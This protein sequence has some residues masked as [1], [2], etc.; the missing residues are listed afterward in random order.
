MNT[1][2]YDIMC[3]PQREKNKKYPPNNNLPTEMDNYRCHSLLT[4]NNF[5][6]DL[7]IFFIY[8][9]RSFFVLQ[10]DYSVDQ[11]RQLHVAQADS[12]QKCHLLCKPRF[13]LSKLCV[14]Y[15]FQSM[16]RVRRVCC[17]L[18]FFYCTSYIQNCRNPESYLMIYELGSRFT[19]TRLQGNLLI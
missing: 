12:F 19:K 8:I 4:R 6:F 13:R 1:S 14:Y 18:S 16:H 17:H 2:P 5:L 10:S 9:L 7:L 11:S 15:A 3:H